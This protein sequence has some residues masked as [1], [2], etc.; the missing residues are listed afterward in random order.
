MK[1][2]ETGS[3]K[4]VLESGVTTN[5]MAPKNVFYVTLL[6][7]TIK[8]INFLF[9]LRPPSVLTILICK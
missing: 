6:T 7:A 8:F 4:S 3:A 9:R 5:G 2:S 1:A